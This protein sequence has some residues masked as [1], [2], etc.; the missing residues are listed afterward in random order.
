MGRTKGPYNAEFEAGS[1]VKIADR[2]TLEEFLNSWKLHNPLQP[3]Q[4]DYHDRVARVKDVSAYH[5][6]D[7]LYQLWG[8]PG[9]WHEQLLSASEI[10]DEER[11]QPSSVT[12]KWVK[13][14]RNFKIWNQR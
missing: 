14:L 12:S 3:E 2:E 11:P 9:I 13:F 8:I 7:E 10:L 4:L 1:W 6:G 5:G